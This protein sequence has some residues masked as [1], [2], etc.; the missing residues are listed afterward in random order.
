MSDKMETERRKEWLAIYLTNGRKGK[1]AALAVGVSETSASRQALKWKKHPESVAEI[2]RIGEQATKKAELT[3]EGMVRE[4]Y[5]LVHTDATQAF[6]DDGTVKPVSQWPEG[7]RHACSGFE[8]QEE[9]DEEEDDEGE[10]GRT[11]RRTVIKKVK[12]YDKVAA[13]DKGMRHFPGGYA[14]AKLEVKDV[15]DHGAELKAAREYRAMQL[16]KKAGE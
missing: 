16:A 6:N 9:V 14:A 10:M 5:M 1:A 11:I 15:S 4:I 12:F 7:L 3:V 13:I 2:N 8:V